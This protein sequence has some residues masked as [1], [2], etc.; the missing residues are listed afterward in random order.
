MVEASEE[1]A[2]MVAAVSTAEADSMVAEG[3]GNAITNR[4]NATDETEKS[5]NEHRNQ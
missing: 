2:S 1:R 5:A 3:T 4:F